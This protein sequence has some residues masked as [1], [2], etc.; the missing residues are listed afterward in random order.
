[1]K[2]RSSPARSGWRT[3]LPAGW[4]FL[5]E[6]PGFEVEVG[7]ELIEGNGQHVYRWTG[8]KFLVVR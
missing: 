6:T 8:E 1:M 5:A 2:A 7:Q 3:A 4:R